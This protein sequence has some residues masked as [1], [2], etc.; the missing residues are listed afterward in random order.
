MFLLKMEETPKSEP[1]FEEIKAIVDRKRPQTIEK[2]TKP[3]P[4]PAPE[5]ALEP[6]QTKPPLQLKPQR[7]RKTKATITTEDT[8]EEK[9]KKN[10]SKN[11]KIMTHILEINQN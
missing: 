3:A 8:P 11:I 5:P 6:E 9:Q 2:K 4:K 10:I 1:T 7:S